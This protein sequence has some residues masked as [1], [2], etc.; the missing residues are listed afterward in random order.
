MNC[1]YLEIAGSPCQ[2]EAIAFEHTN[3]CREHISQVATV[4]IAKQ[5]I[6]RE[7]FKQWLIKKY[8][9]FI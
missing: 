5:P 8:K 3:W 9:D 4:M 6:N 2:R 1:H 7:K